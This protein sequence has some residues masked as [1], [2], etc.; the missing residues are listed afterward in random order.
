[1]SRE[2][3]ATD[4]YVDA[5]NGLDTQA[6]G[7][8]TPFKTITHALSVA[9]SADRIFV[10]PGVYDAT[11]GEVFPLTSTST[12]LQI[13]GT[14]TPYPVITAVG[15]SWPGGTADPACMRPADGWQLGSL[16]FDNAGYV[17]TPGNPFGKIHAIYIKDLVSSFTA[18]T[19][20]VIDNYWG[21]W[22]EDDAATTH[23]SPRTVT[24]HQCT[25]E[26]QGPTRLG[27]IAT[28]LGHAALMIGTEVTLTA[29]ITACTFM[30]NHDGIEGGQTNSLGLPPPNDAVLVVS[31]CV[32]ESNENGL[33][34]NDNDVTVNHCTFRTNQRF[35]PNGAG[36][37]LNPFT[38]ALGNRAGGTLTRYVVRRCVFDRNQIGVGILDGQDQL[39][40]VVF[41]F[42]TSPSDAG[43][44][45]FTTDTTN[46]WPNNFN[47]SYCG[48][49]SKNPNPVW[50]VG[51]TWTYVAGGG[52][53]NQ[54]ADTQGQYA[55]GST[56]IIGPNVN[57]DGSNGAPYHRPVIGGQSNVPWNHST[58]P[59]A[60]SQ[61]G[62]L[63]VLEP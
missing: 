62:P 38:V 49:F 60:G 46:P 43:L 36:G 35:D 32:F 57:W 10:A 3:A 47:P 14:G 33:E 44:N 9:L 29:T 42:G 1:M 6:G 20:E 50:A 58:A 25:F 17:K 54:G 12:N 28:D 48:V 21:I 30:N 23:H 55:S 19:L 51:N 34:G 53:N 59:A 5:V 11:N 15:F 63:I 61:G 18:R 39:S 31:D 4:W 45:T 16:R 24:L 2:A 40:G 7:P 13:Y 41:D 27:G 37:V 8:V 26:D 22:I 52:A 56:L